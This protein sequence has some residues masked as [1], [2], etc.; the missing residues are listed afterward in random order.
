M[1]QRILLK[2][3]D[4]CSGLWGPEPLLA[5]GGPDRNPLWAGRPSVQATHTPTDTHAH[6]NRD[7]VDTP[8]HMQSFGVWEETEPQRK[9]YRH[10]ENMRTPCRWWPWPRINFFSHQCYNKWTKW[11]YL[12]T[13]CN[14]YFLH[15]FALLFT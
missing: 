7:N 14:F 4:S 9:P 6:S 2:P 10:G 13:G 3:A 15:G 1:S 8:F 5:A 11:C 12:R